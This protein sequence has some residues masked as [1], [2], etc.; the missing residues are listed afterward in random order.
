MAMIR[1][2]MAIAMAIHGNTNWQL[3]I[4]IN[5]TN[6]RHTGNANRHSGPR[7]AKRS[8]SPHVRAAAH[9]DKPMDSLLDIA[10]HRRSRACSSDSLPPA[11]D[12]AAENPLATLATT[13][14]GPVAKP[15]T[16]T[17]KH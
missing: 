12:P 3:L 6:N 5:A 8:P 17:E 15:T 4:A 11:E 13:A 2:I 9:V 7:F 16:S 10:R 1:A 14:E